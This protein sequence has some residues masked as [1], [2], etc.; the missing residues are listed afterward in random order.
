DM[1]FYGETAEGMMANIKAHLIPAVMGEDPTN[2]EKVVAKM[3]KALPHHYSSYA[4]IEFALW[5]LK[6]KAL[7]VPVYQLLGGKVRDGVAIMGFV[8]HDLPARMAEHAEEALADRPY[9]VLK[10]K[11]G[12]DPQEDVR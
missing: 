12:L 9:P 5:D 6:G 1:P 11:I 2:I 10:M 8:H 7:G 3:H 4:A